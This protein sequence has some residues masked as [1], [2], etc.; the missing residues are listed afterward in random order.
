MSLW[1]GRFSEASDQDL[2]ALN[3]SIG[4]DIRFYREDIEG[5]IVYALALADAEVIRSDEAQ[6]IVAGLREVLQEFETGDFERATEAYETLVS[7]VWVGRDTFAGYQ[8]AIR[9]L[10]STDSSNRSR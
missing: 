5:S 6:A 10:E 2:R 7:E 1:G 9:F 8:E 4:F 3:D